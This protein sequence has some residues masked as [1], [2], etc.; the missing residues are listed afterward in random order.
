VIEGVSNA[1]EVVIDRSTYLVCFATG[2]PI[3]TISW[4]KDRTA[5]NPYSDVSLN[6][7]IDI[8]EFDASNESDVSSGYMGSGSI[9]EF[10]SGTTVNRSDIMGLGEL[11]VVSFLRFYD[12]VREDTAMYSCVAVNALPQTTQLRR[13][14]NSVQLTVLGK[15]IN[16]SNLFDRPIFIAPPPLPTH[17]HTYTY[18]H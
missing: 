17:M 11:G 16:I 2:F 5:I 14:S 1:T 8:F 13:E 3:P 4:L 7:R 15:E 9:E 6:M 10:L 12:V 18:T